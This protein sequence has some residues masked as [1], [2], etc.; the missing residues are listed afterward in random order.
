MFKRLE[1][2]SAGD[3]R[4]SAL[5]AQVTIR[6]KTDT[7]ERWY[8]SCKRDASG[9]VP[10]KGR[11]VA[12]VLCPFSG[13]R[14]Q[15]SALTPIYQSLWIKYLDAHPELVAYAKGF[16]IFTDQFRG[17][18]TNVSADVIRAYVR[19][20]EKL[21]ESVRSTEYYQSLLRK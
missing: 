9:L 10:G 20:S 17:R 4:F 18:A 19:D 8:Q 11:A 12:Y 6:G 21:K 7:I 15:P 3:R 5:Y 2:S 13:R 16:D 1:C 14:F